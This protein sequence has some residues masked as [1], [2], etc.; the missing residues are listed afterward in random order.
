MSATFTRLH[1]ATRIH[2]GLLRAIGE[3]IDVGRMLRQRD[4]AEEV[5]NVCRGLEDL[6]MAEL[7][8]RF[9]DYTADESARACMEQAA[10][11][12]RRAL[13][14]IPRR[15]P[16]VPQDMSWSSQTS[17]FGLTQ[18]L[19][20]LDD[21]PPAPRPAKRRFSPSDWLGLGG[22]RNSH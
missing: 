6:A 16:T 4:Y 3:G 1:L 8:D 11:E 2:F 5:L 9:D 13:A 20:A 14:Q 10:R 21:T 17:G 7:A 22:D 12:A 18:A 19:A 15:A